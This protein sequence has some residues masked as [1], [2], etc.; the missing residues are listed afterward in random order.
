MERNRLIMLQSHASPGLHQNLVPVSTQPSTTGLW[1]MG[2]V[3]TVGGETL[4][5]FL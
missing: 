2:K 5:C 3:F 4:Q 1:V